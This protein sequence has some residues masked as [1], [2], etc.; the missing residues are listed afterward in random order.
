MI[1]NLHGHNCSVLSLHVSDTAVSSAGQPPHPPPKKLCPWGRAVDT[2][3]TGLGFGF[4]RTRADTF[5]HC[6]P[7]N[8][9]IWVAVKTDRPK[10]FKTA[11]KLQPLEAPSRTVAMVTVNSSWLHTV[12]DMD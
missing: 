4:V 2:E 12:Q 6:F 8:T 9:T 7:S 10:T 11:L 1:G 5:E 3:K